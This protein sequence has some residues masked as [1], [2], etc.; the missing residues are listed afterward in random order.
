MSRL[1]AVSQ[2]GGDNKLCKFMRT[3]IQTLLCCLLLFSGAHLVAAEKQ[4]TPAQLEKLN[5]QIKTV[6]NRLRRNRGKAEKLTD[7]LRDSEREISQVSKQ[8]DALD[9]HLGSLVNNSQVLKKKR[10]NLRQAL[11]ARKQIIQAQIQQQFKL[12]RQPR[13]ELLLNM[14]SPD[15]LSRQMRYFDDINQ[16]LANQLNAFRQQLV[17]LGSTEVAIDENT[18]Q[19]ID[20]RKALDAQ[21]QKLAKAV[22]KRRNTLASLKKRISKDKERLIKLKKD[23]QQMAALLKELQQV[24]DLTELASNDKAFKSLKGKLPWPI[25][26]KLIR[27]FGNKQS[28]VSFDGIWIAGDIGTPVRAVHHGRVVFSDWLRGYGMV[29]II[30]HG[31]NYMSLYGYNQSLL[32]APGDWV[33]AGDAIATVGNSGGH[34]RS[35]LYFAIRYNSRSSNPTR[36]LAKR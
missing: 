34:S 22:E 8:I 13:I 3:L 9:Q 7:T 25:K 12:G 16:A 2:T 24:L 11:S 27:G 10:D 35:G 20:Q 31:N 29:T 21:Q 19:M 15:Q 32:R 33:S 14:Q 1:I 30:D 5:K 17:E 6:S 36:W 26:G 23:Q 4:P 28:G 18:Q